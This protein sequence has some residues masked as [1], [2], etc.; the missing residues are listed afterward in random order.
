[1]LLARRDRLVLALAAGV[2]L[3]LLASL[4]LAY[5]PRPYDQ[6]R[7][8][9]HA[10][11]FALFALLIAL[12]MRVAGLPRARWRYAA[13]AAFVSLIAWPTIVAPV[14]NLGL[15]IGNGVALA[16]AQPTQTASD[17]FFTHDSCS[18]TSPLTVSRSTFAATPRSTRASSPL[19]PSK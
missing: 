14:R 11:N 7:L 6:V 1:M 2:G 4:V 9:R 17:A 3:L 13:G 16:N 18:K 15:A 12:T 5:E 19:T 10:R 8:E